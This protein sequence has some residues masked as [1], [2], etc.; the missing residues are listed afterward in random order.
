MR[1]LLRSH[2]WYLSSSSSSTTL[3][4]HLQPRHLSSF[5]SHQWKLQQ[6]EEQVESRN[7][8]V[9]VW[10]DFK[11][12]NL[13]LGFDASKVAPAIMHAVRTNGIKGPLNITAFGDVHQLSRTFQES[14]AYTGVRLTHVSNDARNNIDILTDLMFWVSQN[15]PPAHL[16]LISGDRDFAGVLHRLRMSNYNILLATPER[17]PSGVLCGAATI[18]WQW[19]SLLKGEDLVGKHFNHPPDGQFGSWYGRYNAP[20]EKL[21][22]A[23]AAPPNVEVYEPSLEGKSGSVPKSVIRQVKHLLSLHPKGVSINDFRDE[24]VKCDLNLDKSWY[25]YKKLSRFLLSLPNVQLQ[26]SGDGN[27]RVHLVPSGSSPEPFE[28]GDVP[29][30]R[31]AVKTEE[32]GN[33]VTSNKGRG[34]D[35]RSSIA[36]AHERSV[37]GDLKSL[38][39]VPSLGK[40]IGENDESSFPSL[41]ERHA[42][43]PSNELQKSSLSS[44]KVVDVADVQRSGI[45]LT[46]KDIKVSETEM[47]SLE[48]TSQKLSG[49]DNVK[50]EDA[51]HRIMEEHTTSVDHSAGNDYATVENKVIANKK[52]GNFEAKNKYENPTKKEVVEEF[53][54]SCSSTSDDSLVDKVHDGSAEPY[55]ENPTTFFGRIRSWWPFRRSSAKYDDLTAHQNKVVSHVQDSRLSKRDQIVSHFEEPELSELDQNVSCS[56]NPELFSSVSFWNEMESFVFAPKGSLLF[57]QSGSREDMA[58]KLQNDGPP[59]LRS[60]KEKDILQLVELLITEKKWLEE[61]PSQTFPFRTTQPVQKNSLMGQSHSA[62]GLRSLF[63]SRTSQSNTNV[64]KSFEHDLEK[65]NQTSPRARV[66]LPATERKDTKKSKHDI[67]EDCQKL[68]S[69]ILREHPEGFNMGAFRR[70]FVDRHGYHLDIQK[71]GHKKLASLLQTIP[72]IKL[73][74]TYI[75]PSVPAINN[76]DLDTSI[77][78]NE[79]TNA[80]DAVSNSDSELS[81]S[82]QQN[83][84]MESQWEELGS[85]SVTN[86]LQS[87]L[88]SNLSQK[89][90][91]MVTSTHPNYEPIVSDDDSS[92]SE[93]DSAC[94]TQPE[95]QGRT[96]CNEQDSSFWQALDSWHSSKDRENHVKKSSGNA[97]VLGNSLADVLNSSAELT[98]GTPSKIPSQNCRM[99]Q[100]SQNNYSFVAD[101]VLPNKDKLIDGVLDGLNESKMQN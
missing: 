33:G 78:K 37:D 58:H 16:F 13:P 29:L 85:V 28:S 8:S 76:S 7:V 81:D 36:S 6:E 63:L 27:F 77:L 12:C 30:M 80:S 94:L 43:Q 95:E 45:Q 67:F 96:K 82:A 51:S 87:D 100:R 15:P 57:S 18:A 61:S 90:R 79:V 46:P 26:P 4:I 32:K 9:S 56:G 68:V 48:T 75:Y 35:A 5:P 19:S 84:S 69:E 10:W 60:L 21:F 44:D 49:D 42:C 11:N 91:K 1:L 17:V 31:S 97:N 24:L 93:G 92:E 55:N 66:S 3:L 20:L 40:D 74:S 99:K 86:S 39:L 62:N 14:L 53:L 22:M 59:V 89:D 72:G 71:L 50:S 83:D 23:A 25:G 88:E 70:L 73:E 52:L 41:G 101:P 98:Q 47:V 65:H 34:V 64:Q 38:Q 2:L 54:S